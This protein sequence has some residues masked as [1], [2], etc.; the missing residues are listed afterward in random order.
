MTKFFH[1]IILLLMLF[2]MVFC[3][4][5]FV[6]AE[7]V[8]NNNSSF[9]N[10]NIAIDSNSNYLSSNYD[11]YVS[12]DVNTSGNG[13]KSNPFKTVQEA[14]NANTGGQS[15]YVSKGMYN[16]SNYE[17]TKNVKLIG[18][19]YSNTVISGDNATHIFIINN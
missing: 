14:L 15:I 3:V 8:E 6:A 18:E 7:N 5:P 1:K 12:S 17:L 13:S 11:L 9:N 2:L 10:N 4:I 16:I 19:N